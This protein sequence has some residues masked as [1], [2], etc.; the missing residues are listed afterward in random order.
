LDV[1]KGGSDSKE[2]LA[3]TTAKARA[4]VVFK[5]V[6][7]VKRKKRQQLQYRQLQWEACTTWRLYDSLRR[8]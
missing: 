1:D 4:K 6:Q 8:P 5:L 3:A 7:A 2:I